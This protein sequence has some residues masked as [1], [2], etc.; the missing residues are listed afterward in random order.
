MSIFPWKRRRDAELDEEIRAH[1]AMATRDRVAG[2]QSPESAEF[3]A[4][5][6][7]GNVTLVKEVTRDTWSGIWLERLAQDVRYAVRSLSRVP[8]FAL[9]SVLTLALGIGANTAIFSVVNGVILRPL[10]FPHPER[11]VFISSDFTP[12]G[13]DHFPIDPAE[14]LELRERSRSFRD[15][16]AYATGA[17]NVGTEDEPERVP[18]AAATAGLF[19]TLGVA[20][21]LGRTFTEAETLPGAPRVAVLSDELWRSAFGG[22]TSILGAQVDIDG[23]RATIIGVMP[24]G[25]DVHDQGVKLWV[26]LVL[27]P[28]KRAQYHGSH[29]L[30]LVGRLQPGVSLDRARSELQS[31]LQQWPATDGVTA[32]PGQPGFIHTP[33][34]TTHRFEYDDLREHMVGGVRTA[35]WVLQAAVVLVLLIAC[36]NMANLMLVRAESRHKELALRAA[37]G[38]GRGRLL[39]QFIVE[40][41]VLSLAG[42]AAGVVLAHLGLSAFVAAD[43]GSIPRAA[44]VTLDGA[45][46]AFTLVL[47]LGSGVV[48]GLAPLLHMNANSVGLALREAG[49]RTTAGAARNR[50]RRG[51][52]VAEMAFAVM[53]VVGAGLLLRS[54]WNLERVDAG[55]DPGHL[56]TFGIALPRQT[57]DGANSV[58]FFDQ[59]TRRLAALPGVR[60]AAAM[61]GLPPRRAMNATDTEI[62]GYAPRPGDPPQ[63]IDYFQFVTPGYVKTMGIRVVSGR[64]FRPSDDA[65]APPVALINETMAKRFYPN[66]DPIGRRIRP[67]FA[68]D[69][70]TI[71]GIVKDVKQGG[72][73][74]KTGTEIYLPYAYAQ[75][76]ERVSNFPRAMN[77][78]VR[79]PLAPSALAGSIRRVVNA[80]DPSLP[81]VSLRSMD[82]VFADSMS[83]P[84]FLAQLLGIFAGVALALAAIGTYGVL[85]YTVTERRRE[86]GIRMALG[87]SGRGVLSL[88]LRQGMVLAG[89]GVLLGLVGALFV[90]RL[91]SSLL[92]GVAPSDP[93]TLGAV[94]VFMGVVAFVACAV[95]ARRATRVDPVVALRTE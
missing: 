4:R 58:A 46:L 64:A 92:F 32:S 56:T 75:A 78:V 51:L 21:R 25:F 7:L 52:V 35:L 42:A 14:Y 29:Y 80:L 71:V 40:G 65:T 49:T 34:A 79:S 93:L 62:E 63:N 72:V 10:P 11:L 47:A 8:G 31:L 30:S 2:G 57:Y 12:L 68:K 20:P 87:A 95:P 60:G 73:D 22:R 1:L 39:R 66:E 3:A 53:L 45:V 44:S 36:A 41:L 82:D 26:P 84:R 48:F 28:A 85:A 81:I 69:W 54:F 50:V 61:S 55:F 18:S 24:P 67:V 38:A 13:L 5:R 9:A 23:E 83:R 74:A 90:T 91:A 88:V 76:A 33:N 19:G 15:I 43:A 6:E 59:L 16:G 70:F 17:V 37:L 94:A 27:D 77:V 89:I 86:I